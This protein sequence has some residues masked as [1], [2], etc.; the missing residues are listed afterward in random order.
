MG[1]RFS[2]CLM[3]R[4]LMAAMLPFLIFGCNS[5]VWSDPF[6]S[7][8]VGQKFFVAPTASGSDYGLSSSN[9]VMMTRAALLNFGPS[10]RTAG[11]RA[12]SVSFKS[13]TL[14]KADQVKDIYTEER[15]G[16]L[17]DSQEC[18]AIQ[19]DIRELLDAYPQAIL[20]CGEPFSTALSGAQGA[21]ITTEDG[22]D[23]E[24][25]SWGTHWSDVGA[26]RVGVHSLSL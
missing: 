25:T 11:S 15:I 13:L 14:I 6:A 9:S 20:V 10:A 19:A 21:V 5:S 8:P 3:M 12:P 24:F 22:K 23:H 7:P 26:Y 4:G 18:R 17:N 16:L 2:T 1:F